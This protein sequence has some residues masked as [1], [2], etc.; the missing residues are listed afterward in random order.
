MNLE[1]LHRRAQATNHNLTRERYSSLV[2]ATLV[3][4]ASLYAL[5]ELPTI[6]LLSATTLIWAIVGQYI[7]HQAKQ[8]S[9]QA[10]LTGL[11]FYRRQLQQRK[12]FTTH[13]L[14]WSIGPFVLAVLGFLYWALIQLH[15]QHLPFVRVLPF[16][17]LF[18]IWVAAAGLIRS[19]TQRHLA[20][21]LKQLDALEQP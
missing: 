7:L 5:L 18:A 12:Y 9:D 3:V 11:Q 19:K 20:E 4:L 17:T 2:L 16:T 14:L 6:R 8:P 10:H 1:D 13:T 21:E 15:A